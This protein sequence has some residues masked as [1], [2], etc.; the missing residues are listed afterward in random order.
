MVVE[1]AVVGAGVIGLSTAYKLQQDIKD[2]QVT[3]FYKECSPDTTGDVSAG[4]IYPYICSGHKVNYWFSETMKYFSEIYKLPNAF[5]MG[6]QPLHGYIYDDGLHEDLKQMFPFHAPITDKERDS[7]N[8]DLQHK[9]T[10]WTCDC[11]LYLPWLMKRIAEQGGKLVQKC[12]RS[13]EELQDFDVI[14]NCAGMGAKKL[15]NDPLLHPVRGQVFVVKAPWVKALFLTKSA[16]V[17]PRLDTVVLG[18]T[19]QRG[20]YNLEVDRVD[21]ARIWEECCRLCP[22]VAYAEVV[23]ERVGLRPF[24]ESTIRVE[25]EEVKLNQRNVP[26][27]HNY[28]HGGG[29]VSLHWGC[30]LESSGILQKF[31]DER[32]A[33]SKL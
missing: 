30:A 8:L 24:R 27:L 12:V 10:T 6:V 33:L 20:D 2:C 9:V 28:G 13:F 15:T 7:L 16:Y 26:I 4:F 19:S 11:G 14:V 17:L 25:L 22:S 29:G 5:E 32:R 31:L 1:I 21:S 3:V 18:G 23:A